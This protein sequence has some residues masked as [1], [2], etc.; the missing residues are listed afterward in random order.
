[1]ASFYFDNDVADDLAELLRV[2][3]HDVLT[4][5]E[6]GQSRA[7]DDQQL[8]TATE[9]GR[10]LVSHNARDFILVHHAWR[11]WPR[12]FGVAWSQHPGIVVLPQP[13]TLSVD[14]AAIELDKFVRS[15]RR[16]G[17]ALYHYR[18]TGG[19]RRER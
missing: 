16:I 10:I 2:R 1:M 11:L 12:A 14:R 17:N 9:L 5:R 19:W 18:V 7:T 13:P 4:T 6:H 3:N 8:L 15:G